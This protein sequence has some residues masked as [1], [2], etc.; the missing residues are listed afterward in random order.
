M[1]FLSI[2]YFLILKHLSETHISEAVEKMS[3]GCI[4]QPLLDPILVFNDLIDDDDGED[5][6]DDDGDV[7]DNAILL[8]CLGFPQDKWS[9]PGDLCDGSERVGHETPLSFLHV[10][11][12]TLL[13]RPISH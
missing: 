6:V 12:F 11:F 2:K 10:C 8:P 7:G 4:L 9:W 1:L 13:F 5:I 3:I